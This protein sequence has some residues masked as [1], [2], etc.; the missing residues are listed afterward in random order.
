MMFVLLYD[1]SFEGLM[2]AIAS[3]YK[4]KEPLEIRKVDDPA[5][6]LIA[7]VED[8]VTDSGQA[9]KVI[10]AIVQKLGME[11]FKRVSY[12][13]FSEEPEVGTALLEFL[14]YAFRTG[15]SAIE[16]LSHPKVRPI[17][18]ASRKVTRELHLMTGLVRFSQTAS[19]IYYSRY[20]PTYDLTA[21][22]APHFIQRLSDQTWV[23]HDVRRRLAAF[24]DQKTW[25][26]GELEPGE[27]AYSDEEI[28]Y[29]DLWH[30]YFK[31]IS[32]ESR[33]SETRQR[34]HMPKKYWKYL[35]EIKP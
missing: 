20:E 3:A 25:W 19:G 26:L 30:A 27:P 17:F 33:L 22:L 29:Q 16:H 14:R 18:E 2:C 34:Q 21:I 7:T 32:I 15:P 31:H 9:R 10:E 11:T 28:S 13:C 6:L 12:A 24:Y 8:I 5:P 23:L 1:G 4:R 35:V